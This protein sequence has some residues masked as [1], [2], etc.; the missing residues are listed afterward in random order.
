MT[1]NDIY[2]PIYPI[3]LGTVGAPHY[4][5]TNIRHSSRSSALL[6]A[7]FGSKPVQFRVLSSHLFLCLPVLPLPVQCPGG[8]SWQVPK[9]LWHTH[10]TSFCVFLQWKRVL[11]RVQWL[12]ESCFAPLRWW[13]GFCKRCQGDVW[14]FSFSLSVS[15]SLFLLLLFKS[16]KNIKI[17]TWPRSAT[18]WSLSWDLCSSRPRWSW[19]LWVLLWSW[20]SWSVFQA[21]ILRQWL[22]LPNIWSFERFPAS[23]HW[24]WCYCWC[25]WCCWSSVWSSQH[26]SACRMR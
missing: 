5:A 3:V 12:S 13:C 24:P 23:R 8:L 14:N 25:H 26:W 16:H 15:F 19:A 10:T 7:S 1:S 4:L 18:V 20:Q 11:R 21:W 22:W 17:W 6:T 9:L 2:L